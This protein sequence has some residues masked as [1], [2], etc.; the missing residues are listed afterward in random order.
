MIELFVVTF[1]LCK[2]SLKEQFTTTISGCKAF[3]QTRNTNLHKYKKTRKL[4]NIKLLN[5]V[6]N[7]FESL[8][9]SVLLLITL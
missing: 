6:N 9:T 7:C 5:F 3:T 1:K 2:V 8:T 4:I